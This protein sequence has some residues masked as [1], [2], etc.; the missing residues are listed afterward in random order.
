MGSHTA[1]SAVKW[2]E[3]GVNE[4]VA[5]LERNKEVISS[6]GTSVTDTNKL[7][8]KL[9]DNALTWSYKIYKQR[10]LIIRQQEQARLYTDMVHQNS[11]TSLNSSDVS[12]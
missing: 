6:V 3:C 2:H 5:W 1:L 10:C 8:A 9:H 7:L 11:S 12:D 4:C